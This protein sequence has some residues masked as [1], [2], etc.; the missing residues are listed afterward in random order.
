MI[1]LFS[2]CNLAWWQVLLSWLLPFLL[3]WWFSRLLNSQY[4]EESDE[5]VTESLDLNSQAKWSSMQADLDLRLKSEASLRDELN[6]LRIELKSTQLQLEDCQNS[7]KSEPVHIDLDQK[8]ELFPESRMS[9]EHLGSSYIPETA[10][11]ALHPDQLQ[12]VEG[13]G[14]KMDEFLKS[15]GIITWKDLSVLDGAQ[16]KKDLESADAKYRIIDP[17]SWP[18]QA[19]LAHHGQ[20]DELIKLQKQLAGG[21]DD[22]SNT[23]TNSKLES[24]LIKMG[25]LKRYDQDDLKAIEGIGPKIELLLHEAGIKTWKALS[26]TAVSDIQAI[27]TA[28]GDR[29]Q[30]A[31]PST[32]PKQADLAARGEWKAFYEYQDQLNGGKEA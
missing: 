11:A 28:A 9:S 29:F 2:I 5:T 23:E 26:N 7:K 19:G 14:P 8:T 6:R 25:L 30:L 3:G 17:A 20:W 1:L 12:I 4:T 21:K 15:K 31:N 32:W 24:V 22:S 10:F 13:I 16:L 27:L 18:Q